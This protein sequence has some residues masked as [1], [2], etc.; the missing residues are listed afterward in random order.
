MDGRTL[1]YKAL[2][3]ISQI[4]SSYGG[5][6]QIDVDLEQLR[7]M[8]ADIIKAASSAAREI[9]EPDIERALRQV[10]CHYLWFC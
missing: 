1:S 8:V 3:G 10:T 2:T 7:R 6:Q 9:D 4:P 5:A